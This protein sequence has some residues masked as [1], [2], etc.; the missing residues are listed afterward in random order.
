MNGLNRYQSQRV[1]KRILGELSVKLWA[2]KQGTHP[3]YI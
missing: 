1:H 2:D 3:Q